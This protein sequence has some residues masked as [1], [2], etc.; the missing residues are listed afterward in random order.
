MN[1]KEAFQAQNKIG[2]L[3]TYITRYLSDE[4]NVTTI[5]E[6]H[7]RSKAL[8]GQ[9]D[10]TADVSRKAGEGFDVGRLLVVWQ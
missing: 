2:E 1:L 4:D 9:Q 5:T 7:L 8:A 3:M 6:K 10:N